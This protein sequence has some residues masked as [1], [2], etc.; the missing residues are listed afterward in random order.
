MFI[1]FAIPY[2]NMNS[3]RRSS[4]TKNFN[5]NIQTTRI[6]NIKLDKKNISKKEKNASMGYIRRASPRFDCKLSYSNAPRRY[7]LFEEFFFFYKVK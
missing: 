7:A 6:F 4:I 5:K 3:K 1:K 2:N